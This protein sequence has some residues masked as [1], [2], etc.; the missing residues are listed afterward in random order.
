M[1]FHTASTT[2]TIGIKAY[3][4]KEYRQRTIV[5]EEGSLCNDYFLRSYEG[6]KTIGTLDFINFDEGIKPITS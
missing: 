4:L 3:I 5:I 6:H 2:I 1:D